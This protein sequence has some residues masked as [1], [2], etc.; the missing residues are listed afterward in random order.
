[1]PSPTNNHSYKTCGDHEAFISTTFFKEMWCKDK[2][3]REGTLH[4]EKPFGN[5]L[6]MNNGKQ[7]SNV[8]KKIASK[9]AASG[10][11]QHQVKKDGNTKSQ[12]VEKRQHAKTMQQVEKE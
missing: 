4:H 12:Q 8:M 6:L 5:L 9:E 2:H 7:K 3:W 1:M 10:R 11:K